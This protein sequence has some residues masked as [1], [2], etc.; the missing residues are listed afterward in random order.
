MT[1][2]VNGLKMISCLQL[3][4]THEWA[5]AIHLDNRYRLMRG[6]QMLDAQGNPTD[7]IGEDETAGRE[8]IIEYDETS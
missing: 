7:Q 8:F 2:L 4:K 3:I 6:E 5:P 1:D